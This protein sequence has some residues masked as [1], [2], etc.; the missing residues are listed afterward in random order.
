MVVIT[1]VTAPMLSGVTAG[2]TAADSL[3]ASLS[4]AA[5]FTSTAGAI[6]SVV[7]AFAVAGAPVPGTRVLAENEILS[8]TITVSDGAG[9]SRSFGA[10]SVTVAAGVA[11][12][13]ITAI[14]ADGWQATWPVP[15]ADV[16]AGQVTVTRQGFD[17]AAAPLSAPETLRVLA[18]VRQP[19]SVSPSADQVALS[20]YV[21]AG[22]AVAAVTNASVRPYPYAHFAWL[23]RDRQEVRGNT[24]FL[25]I[26]VAHRHARNGR[27]V[28][29]VRFIVKDHLGAETALLVTACTPQ[30]YPVSGLTACVYEGTVD[31]SALSAVGA[32]S[33]FG[34][35]DAKALT[36]DAEFRPWIGTAH[37]ISTITAGKTADQ[38]TV[39]TF[40]NN[41]DNWRPTLY[42][43]V[44]VGATGGAVS[45]DAATAATTPFPTT[46]S[47]NTALRNWHMT[48]TGRGA[49]DG[50]VMRLTEGTHVH[51]T[52]AYRAADVYA[53]TF[54]N[55]PGTNPANV[56]YTDGG[57]TTDT[58][59]VRMVHLRNLTLRKSGTA[60]VRMLDSGST[61]PAVSYLSAQN[62]V[63]DG[64]A[65]NGN[66][67]YRYGAT[68]YEGCSQGQRYVTA[69]KVIGCRGRFLAAATTA[70]VGTRDPNGQ[71]SPNTAAA[72]EGLFVAWSF[73]TADKSV[74]LQ[75]V[76][77]GWTTSDLG[78]ALV[79]NVFEIFGTGSGPAVLINGDGNTSSS[80]NITMIGNTVVGGRMNLSYTDAGGAVRRDHLSVLRF[81]IFYEKNHKAGD[82]FAYDGETTNPVRVGNWS[83][84]YGVGSLANTTLQGESRPNAGTAAYPM[85]WFGDV[86]P[87]GSTAGT[88]ATPLAVSF[89]NDRSAGAGT[90]DG[91]YRP[92]G[93][94]DLAVIPAG[95][96][97]WPVDLKGHVLATGG[98]AVAGAL[99]PG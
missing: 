88:V 85:S 81:N 76:S 34:G 53:M 63:C 58:S 51:T 10:G 67:I 31:I 12:P 22:D 94:T 87:T 98:G 55:A 25:R 95:L 65:P 30:A 44:A 32:P 83:V 17:A 4:S 48:N 19:G 1:A 7:V 52:W 8:A 45:T 18:R 26:A 13:M 20:D 6:T 37:R 82:F 33:S 11:A 2:Q 93:T 40:G 16:G 91:D 41:R 80:R 86:L 90:G 23:V 24:I 68:Y 47:A 27:P 15:P 64:A 62:V 42:A 92:V 79:G 77:I 43:Y 36:I 66:V 14:A 74:Y 46:A 61:D 89:A 84:R 57:A 56:I 5:N 59:F 9:N 96:T 78:V 75:T 28:A 54:E 29:G 35:T 72:A 39:L 70:C 21:Y 99:Q 60:A 97:P 49:M 38:N 69:N 73:I 71:I 50:C 3:S